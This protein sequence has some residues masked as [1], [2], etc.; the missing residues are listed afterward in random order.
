[1]CSGRNVF[2]GYLKDESRTMRAF[3]E[4]M[5]LHTQD[6]GSMSEDGFLKINGR[7]EGFN[8]VIND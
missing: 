1:M 2:M 7:I 4:E 5:W 8:Y 3:N 6:L